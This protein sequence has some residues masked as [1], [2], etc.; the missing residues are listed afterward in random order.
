VALSLQAQ[1]RLLQSRNR[2]FY[3]PTIGLNA[4]S[5]YNLYQGGY[6]AEPPPPQF[7][8]LLPEPITSPTW[9]V[10]LG[11]TFPVFQ[12]GSRRAEQQ[13]TL[14][15]V[16]RIK[17]QQQDLENQLELRIRSVLQQTGASY[18]EIGLS[19]QAAE[20]AQRNLEIAQDGYREGVVP[21]AQLIDAQEA[22]LQSQ[23]LAS[24][25]VFSFLVDFLTVERAIGFYYFLAE[26]ADQAAFLER[27]NLFL[28]P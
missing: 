1:E 17:N 4:S 6:E 18:A 24:N 13:Q 20:A 23:I 12:G 16:L 14:V 21:V 26:P 28:N 27:L 8:G 5:G 3:L 15:D 11:L 19:R 7:E 9:G 22:A 10:G 2:A 25:A